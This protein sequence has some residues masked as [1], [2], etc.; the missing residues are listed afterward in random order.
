MKLILTTLILLA[1]SAAALAGPF[2]LESERFQR[3]L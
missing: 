2:D 3:W 1:G